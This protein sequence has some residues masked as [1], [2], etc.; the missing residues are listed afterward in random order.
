MTNAAFYILLFL[1]IYLFLIGSVIFVGYLL[2]RRKERS[3]LAGGQKITCEELVVIVPFKAFQ[4][5]RPYPKNSFSSMIILPM[6][7]QRTFKAS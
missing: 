1:G 7:R 2:Q 3:Y 4:P 5:L 6:I